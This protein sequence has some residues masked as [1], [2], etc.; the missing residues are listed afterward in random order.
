MPAPFVEDA[1][2]YPWYTFGFFVKNQVSVGV[3]IYVLDL[4]SL[5]NL[6]VFMPIPCGFY[7]S[8]SAVELEIRM[9]RPPAVLS[10][11]RIVLAILIFFI[12]S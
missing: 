7:Y 4:G 12:C 11:Y 3:W 1:F 2:F 9:V 5:I 10:L 8:G 6:S